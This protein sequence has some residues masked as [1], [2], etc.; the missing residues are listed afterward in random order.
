MRKDKSHCGGGTGMEGIVI[1]MVS[2]E[3]ITGLVTTRMSATCKK[4]SRGKMQK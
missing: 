4:N 2:K 3:Q 1:R